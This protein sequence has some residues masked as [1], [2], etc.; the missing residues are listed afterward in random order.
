MIFRQLLEPL[1]ST[2]TYLSAARRPARHPHRPGRQRDGTRS[3]GALEAAAAPRPY[4]RDA[5]HADHI[6]SALHSSSGPAVRSRPALERLPC[7][8]VTSRTVSRFAWVASRSCPSTRRATRT[9]TLPTPGP[10]RCSPATRCHRRLRPD[11][12]PERRREG[13]LPQRARAP[14]HAAGRSARLS[15]HD[16][17]RRRV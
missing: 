11:R 17:N 1:S 2:Y 3:R 16:Y 15:G 10:T 4:P 14:L 9:R 6:T 13:A 7:A 8:D 12:L 5:R